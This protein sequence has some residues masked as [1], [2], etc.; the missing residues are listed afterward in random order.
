M[1]T[2]S[3]PVGKLLNCLVF[4][5]G[6]YLD[7][8]DLLALFFTEIGR[9]LCGVFFKKKKE[10]EREGK[11]IVL[12]LHIPELLHTYY[13]THL[14]TS[15]WTWCIF[16]LAQISIPAL[17]NDSSW[18]WC[19][20]RWVGVVLPKPKCLN[21]RDVWDYSQKLF[22]CLC[23]NLWETRHRCDDDYFTVLLNETVAFAVLQRGQRSTRKQTEN[24]RYS[25][26]KLIPLSL[27]SAPS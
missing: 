20:T 17:Q 5:C 8:I 4:T 21:R 7:G 1:W 18:A 23:N 10:I 15:L 13:L 2:P 22:F 14:L 9:K 25:L 26:L 12:S 6:F 24:P 11:S 19:S 3:W 16:L 27:P